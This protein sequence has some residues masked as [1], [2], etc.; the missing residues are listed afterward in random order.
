MDFILQF[1][2]HLLPSHFQLLQFASLLLS[3]IINSLQLI[4]VNFQFITEHLLHVI[5]IL[6]QLK[7]CKFRTALIA[8][9][10]QRLLIT[11]RQRH[12][13]IRALLAHRVA[14]PFAMKH[15]I[16]EFVKFPVAHKTVRVVLS[17]IPLLIVHLR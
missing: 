15:L 9:P 8:D 7:V 16:L 6:L 3:P 14:A 10:V 5:D 11:P 2:L 4:L 1:M 13:L 12:P 17:L